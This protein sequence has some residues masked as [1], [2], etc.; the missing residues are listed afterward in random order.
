MPA[1]I[2]SLS[3]FRKAKLRAS[4]GLKAAE[5]RV[6]FGLTK[7]DK[8]KAKSEKLLAEKRVDG[9]RLNSSNTSDA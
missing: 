7:A 8:A 3:K 2:L 4:D 5:N 9:H 1:D 6:L